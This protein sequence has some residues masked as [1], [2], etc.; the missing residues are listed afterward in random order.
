MSASYRDVIITMDAKTTNNAINDYLNLGSKDINH[1]HKK[2]MICLIFGNYL[3]LKED[4]FHL[5]LILL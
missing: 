5:S 2:F 3:S 1:T 4:S